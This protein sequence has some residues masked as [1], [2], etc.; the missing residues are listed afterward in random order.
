MIPSK[1]IGRLEVKSADA[2]QEMAEAERAKKAAALEEW[3]DEN[4]QRIAWDLFLLLQGP[5]LWHPDDLKEDLDDDSPFAEDNKLFLKSH[6]AYFAMIER[7]LKYGFEEVDGIYTLKKAGMTKE[8]M[9][10]VICLENLFDRYDTEDGWLLSRGVMAQARAL[11]LGS[12]LYNEEISNAEVVEKI[13]EHRGGPEW[14]QVC[15]TNAAQEEMDSSFG[16]PTITE[17]PPPGRPWVDPE[18]PPWKR[19]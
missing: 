8:E 1:R 2:I 17:I 3:R 16:I 6:L 7:V 4:C 13:D 18:H 5:K 9:A 15:G 11:G 10:F 14:R 12:A 19:D